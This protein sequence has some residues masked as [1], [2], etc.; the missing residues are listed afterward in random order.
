MPTLIVILRRAKTSLTV[1]IALAT[2][3]ASTSLAFAQ[4]AL[5]WKQFDAEALAD[6]QAYLRFDTSNPPDNTA[7]AIAFLKQILDKE[8]I[9]SQVFVTK[10]G[11]A[12]LVAKLPGPAGVKPLLLMSHADVV[13][14]V[15]KD[16]NHA[17]FS[18]DLAGG[19][20]WGRGAIDNKAHGIMALMTM[21]ALKRSGVH[22]KRGVTMMVNCDEEAGGENGANWMAA[23]HWDSF[24]PAFA[25]NEG[26][27]GTPNWL[28]SRGVTFRIAVSEKRVMWLRLTA[29]GKAGHGSMPNANNPNLILIN[30]LARL[31]AAQPPFR[32]TPVFDEA[33]RTLAPRMDYPA[34]FE[35]AH[36]D[37]PYMMDIAARGPL[38][39]YTIQAA[40]H[41]TIAPTM[42]TSGIKV[43]VIPSMAEAGI[44]CRLLPDT[45]ADAFLK[46]L[47]DV[48][49]PS[50][51]IDFIQHPDPSPTSPT[52][53]EAWDAMKQVVADDFVDTVIAPNMTSGGTDSRFLRV[54]GVPAYGFVPIILPEGEAVRIHGVDERLSIDNLNRG[55]HV[56]YELAKK[57]CVGE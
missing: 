8:G 10:P 45:D 4:A 26:G 3:L 28:G 50:I 53:G 22:L 25:F 30:A 33:M 7:D 40:M 42:L 51:D 41:D 23:N 38:S 35:L 52:A 27:E 24:D 17:P 31:L 57:L 37:W 5:D 48:L 54:K 15:A 18:G 1:L 43:N 39:L 20:V 36:L 47:H 29:H 6:F 19:F 9:E 49:G 13:P 21:L 12:N 46:H 32:L 55:I 56:T 16:W 34:S 44:D 2:M 14:V 11:M